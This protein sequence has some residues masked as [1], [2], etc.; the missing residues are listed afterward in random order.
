MVL[1]LPLA[2]MQLTDEVRWNGADFIFAGVLIGAV[3]L[4]Y[5]LAVSR[6]RDRAYRAGVGVALAA[7]F[8]L[9][10]ANGA[11]GLIGSEDNPAN[12]LFGLVPLTALVGAMLAAF[13]PAGMARALLAAAI[14]QLLVTSTVLAIGWGARSPVWPREFVLAGGG[15]CG[16]WLASAWLFG[17]AARTA[18]AA[19]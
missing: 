16:L 18:P 14:V 5:E 7:T 19:R 2:A 8:L 12:L 11:V 9:V 1:L 17:K 13:R 15:F 6:T 10:W 4:T 3:G